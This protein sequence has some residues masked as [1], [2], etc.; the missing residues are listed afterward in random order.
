MKTTAH[1][2]LAIIAI[3]AE[4][5]GAQ[6]T[7]IKLGASPT[8]GVI[9]TGFAPA[10]SPV[11]VELFM[12]EAPTA[13]RASFA[14]ENRTDRRI[15]A[16]AV[17]YAIKD[18]NGVARRDINKCDSFL[19]SGSHEVA[20]PGARVLVAPGGI[21]M[22]ES[23]LA[24]GRHFFGVNPVVI[25]DA[26]E[27]FRGA[28][29]IAIAVDS[30]IFEDGEVV[31]PDDLKFAAEIAA[32]KAAAKSLTAK[33]RSAAAAGQNRSSVIST[34]AGLSARSANFTE[35]WTARY[36]RSIQRSRDPDAFV[37]YM[38]SLPTPPTFFRKDVEK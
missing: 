38:D 20:L 5:C 8:A 32:R 10:D 27:S 19:L 21:F 26:D 24:R 30:I 4:V 15:L 29:E 34:L 12:A 11:F 16:I 3:V 31:G 36:I 7:E 2:T 17:T 22:P 37:N 13:Q 9:V 18:A 1:F 6:V 14:L 35:R 25:T 23:L 33:F 28:K